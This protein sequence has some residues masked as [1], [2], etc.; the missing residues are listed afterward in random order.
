MS[1]FV[2]QHAKSPSFGSAFNGAS[3]ERRSIPDYELS[4]LWWLYLPL[5]FFALRYLVHLYTH[6][7]QGFEAWFRNETGSQKK[8]TTKLTQQNKKEI[9]SLTCLSSSS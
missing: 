3:A 2:D 7:K 4:R 5:V 9:N 1:D 8:K 6:P